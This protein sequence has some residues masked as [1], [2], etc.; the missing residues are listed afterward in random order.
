MNLSIRH[1][2][3][4]LLAAAPLSPSQAQTDA[5][6]GAG[7]RVRIA[8][9]Q[10]LAHTVGDKVWPG[11]SRTAFPILLVTDSAEYLVNHPRPT[12]ALAS[13]GYDSLVG[14]EIWTRPR[15]FPPGMLATFPVFGMSPTV[16]VGT[17]ER[18]GKESTQW[19]LTLLHEHFHQR[20]YSEPLYYQG[21]AGLGL[22]RGDTTG[23]WMLDY[24]FPYDSAPVQLAMRDL[25]TSL[26]RALGDSGNHAV[27][28]V[29]R[30]RDKLRRRLGADDYRYFEFQL[31]QEGVAR[32]TE[33]AVARAAA[34]LDP[35]PAEFQRLPD[36]EPYGRAAEHGIAKLRRELEQMDLGK[37]RRVAFYPIGAAIALLLDR[38]SPGWKQTYARRRFALSSLLPLRQTR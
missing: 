18:T 5:P 10:R 33:Y 15:Q 30:A 20:Q 19:V 35:P 32:Y 14:S 23:S 3:L 38:T 36:Y 2:A 4:A 25:A 21:V 26:L 17:A 6:L 9:A 8:E 29:V 37:Q 12:S 31:W 13:L 24:P 11:W 27:A 34:R 16:V 7:D 22:A 1:L 28:G